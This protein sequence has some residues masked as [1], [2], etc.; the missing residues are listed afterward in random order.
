MVIRMG[1]AEVGSVSDR[2]DFGSVLEDPA[3]FFMGAID[4]ILRARD[5]T[6]SSDIGDDGH[7]LVRGDFL[8]NLFENR[9][10]TAEQRF[11][12]FGA[13]PVP[14]LQRMSDSFFHLMNLSLDGDN[15]LWHDRGLVLLEHLTQAFPRSSG[16]HNP[17]HG[18]LLATLFQPFEKIRSQWTGMIF[19][20]K[21]SVEI[22]ANQETFQWGRFSS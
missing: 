20:R 19:S 10:V 4:A 14:F 15:P 1:E 6:D 3:H 7:F 13:G 16:G 12:N 8:L 5:E 9:A 17:S 2:G 11:M 18:A 22:R 21:G